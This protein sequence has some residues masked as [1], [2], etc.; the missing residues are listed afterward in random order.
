MGASLSYPEVDLA[1]K[2]AIVTGGNT[3]IG[4]ETGKALARMGARVILA[5]RSEER[6][7]EVGP[8]VTARPRVHRAR[9][10]H[11]AGD[12]ENA[13]RAGR[14]EARIGREYQRRV[15]GTR[16]GFSRVGTRLCQGLLGA[17]SAASSAHSQRRNGNASLTYLFIYI[18]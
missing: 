3:G 6:A 18:K 13:K 4:Y 2:V 5:C 17:K 8:T 15:Y 16:S 7:T 1:G 12:Q 9:S 10:S 11:F 14:S